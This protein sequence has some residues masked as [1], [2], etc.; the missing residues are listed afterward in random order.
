MLEREIPKATSPLMPGNG[1][2]EVDYDSDE[3]SA[4]SQPITGGGKEESGAPLS[5]DY[6]QQNQNDPEAK[7]F[8]GFNE[9]NSMEGNDQECISQPVLTQQ[10]IMDLIVNQPQPIMQ[11]PNYV[12]GGWE[13][14]KQGYSQIIGRVQKPHR[15]HD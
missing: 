3:D 14:K 11:P 2:D 7:G 1:D 15:R 4:T 10:I 13:E 6:G 5:Q 12:P 8:E 9:D